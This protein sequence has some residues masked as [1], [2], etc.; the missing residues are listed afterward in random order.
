MAL[1]PYQPHAP[2]P[3][4]RIP[5]ITSLQES[6]TNNFRSIDLKLVRS[7]LT[8]RRSKAQQ[9]AA[10]CQSDLDT[11]SCHWTRKSRNQ[12]VLKNRLSTTWTLK[13]IS[14]YIFHCHHPDA[15]IGFI[16]AHCH[17]HACSHHA[18]DNSAQA[19]SKGALH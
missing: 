6:I 19:I 2:T 10:N 1:A 12:A 9:P 3:P 14:K 18:A 4:T 8:P 7:K 17:S 5:T 15:H 16:D 11:I 13:E